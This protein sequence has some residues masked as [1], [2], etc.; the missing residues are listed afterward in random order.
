[1]TQYM[2][3]KQNILRQRTVA[4]IMGIPLDGDWKEWFPIRPCVC[5]TAEGCPCD[6]LEDIIVWISAN[7][8]PEKTG[9]KCQ[10]DELLNYHL[11]RDTKILVETQIPMTIGQLEKIKEVT[12]NCD[13]KTGTIFKKSSNSKGKKS[14]G[15]LLIGAFELG[16]FIGEK[17][18]EETD[19]SGKI[20]DWLAETIPWPR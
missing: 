6:T 9:K 19:V 2:N 12:E 18:D 11:E 20:S 3:T 4:S 13:G 1:M 7:V 5:V 10:G 8:K 15:K 17:I 14:I 16:W